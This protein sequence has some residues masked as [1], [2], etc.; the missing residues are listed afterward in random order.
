M[1]A[2]KVLWERYGFDTANAEF[3][4]ER[5]VQRLPGDILER[6]RREANETAGRRLHFALERAYELL[7]HLGDP[8]GEAFMGD[9][10]HEGDAPEKRGGKLASALTRR[11]SSLLGHGIQPISRDAAEDMRRRIG[12]LVEIAYDAE[13][14]ARESA[15]TKPVRFLL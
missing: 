7:A 11:N 1:L 14:L 5:L 3:S 8:L 2:Q 13:E 9:Y 12:E 10:R 4:D 6:Y 15:K